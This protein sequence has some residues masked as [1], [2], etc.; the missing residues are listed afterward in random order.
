MFDRVDL[1]VRHPDGR[2]ERVVL[3]HQML[4]PALAVLDELEAAGRRGCEAKVVTVDAPRRPFRFPRGALP[5]D[6][7]DRIRRTRR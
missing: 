5:I 6:L 1:D 3:F 2:V 4:T 7:V